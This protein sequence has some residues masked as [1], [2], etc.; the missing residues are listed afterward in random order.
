MEQRRVY[1]KS[2]WY[3][4]TQSRQQTTEVLALVPE[5][6]FVTDRFLL[7]LTLPA[8]I[9]AEAAGWLTLARATA[10][11]L[12]PEN[13]ATN[14]QQ[15]FSLYERLSTALTVAQVCGVQRLCNHYAA[16]L[17]PL[18]GPDSSR[19][20]NYRLAQITQYARQLSASP[21]IITLQSR[22]HLRDVG[23]TAADIVL[24]TQI[25]GFITWQAR[26]IAAGHALLGVPVRWIPGMPVQDDADALRFTCL[27]CRWMADADIAA[28][29]M[30]GTA[31][32]RA[33][34]LLKP[35]AALLVW[36]E[37]LRNAFSAL[38]DLFPDDRPA[39]VS[40]LVTAR[41]NGS[42]SCFNALAAGCSGDSELVEAIRRSDTALRHWLSR[43]P[44]DSAIILA[45]QQ[46]TRAPDRFSAAQVAPLAASGYAPA[47]IFTRLAWCGLSGWLNRL[48]IGLG[49]TE[50]LA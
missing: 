4:E 2:Q 26:V 35:L 21:S 14:R 44:Q 46:L 15:T 27:S 39:R 16:R 29:S 3:H 43:H 28:D 32:T 50:P 42:V 47:Q 13:V 7:D 48:K 18:P 45:S 41:I 37:S 36:D 30:Q 12:L 23:L 11:A 8:E 25:V 34:G 40:G 5:A 22:Q 38:P 17:A 6:A 20:S 33:H 19:E 9:T 10:A 24:I 49:D 31:N 1:G